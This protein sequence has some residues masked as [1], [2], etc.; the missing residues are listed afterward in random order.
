MLAV[1]G[2]MPVPPFPDYAAPYAPRTSMADS[3]LRIDIDW[4]ELEV[5]RSCRGMQ[6]VV[7]LR[8]WLLVLQLQVG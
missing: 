7:W 3:I 6:E 5:Q 1:S 8:S 2:G 4:V